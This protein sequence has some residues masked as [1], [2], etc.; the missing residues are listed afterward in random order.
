MAEPVGFERRNAGRWRFLVRVD[1]WNASLSEQTMALVSAAASDKHPQTLRLSA[2]TG[3]D[4]QRFLKIYSPPG[5]VG[6][7]KDLLRDSKAMRALKMSA[8]LRRSGFHAPP[9]IAAGEE[10]VA[11]RLGKAFL[12]TAEIA[13]A[14]LP[15]VVRDRFIAPSHASGLRAKRAWIRLLAEEIRRLHDAGFVHGDLVASNV[16]IAVG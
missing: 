7:I 14:P 4:T 16:F 12:V 5:G 10:R 15:Q 1:Q 2:A 9:P 11:G 3:S 6:S 13:A 8:A